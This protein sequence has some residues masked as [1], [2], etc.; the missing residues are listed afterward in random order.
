MSHKDIEEFDIPGAH[1]FHITQ[2]KNNLASQP[3]HTVWMNGC[4]IGNL[5]DL[6]TARGYLF[7]QACLDL[8]RRI[9]K[10]KDE[11]AVMEKS[12]AALSNDPFNL[13]QFRAKPKRAR[14]VGGRIP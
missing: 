10:A 4:A 12:R 13:G 5:K 6:K 3:C 8:A 7:D 1:Y 9:R 14:R 2:G 11:L